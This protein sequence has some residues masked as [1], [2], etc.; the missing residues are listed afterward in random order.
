MNN[1]K[2][3]L[4]KI[5]IM[6]VIILISLFFFVIYPKYLKSAT[7]HDSIDKINRCF[8]KLNFNLMAETIDFNH[9]EK[10]LFMKTFDNLN[11]SL[12]DKETENSKKEKIKII[13]KISLSVTN[14]EYSKYSA[15]A[16]MQI[17]FNDDSINKTTG[18][19]DKNFKVIFNRKN[20]QWLI[21]QESFKPVIDNISKLI[22]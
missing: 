16:L 1:S 4:I 3:N 14:I 8:D 20:N 15:S 13:K 19:K 6:T 21:T 7:P 2:Q 5:V 18:V 17:D 10:I 9:D 12:N 11:K 22:K